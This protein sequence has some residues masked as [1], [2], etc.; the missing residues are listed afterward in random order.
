MSAKVTNPG[1]LK[2]NL[3]WNTSYDDIVSVHDGD[4]NYIVDES[5]DQNLVAL[6]F[7]WEKLS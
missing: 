6:A 7:L 2:I 3:F 1:L 4:S 5:C